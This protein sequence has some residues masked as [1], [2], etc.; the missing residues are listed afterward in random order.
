MSIK[1]HPLLNS[2]DPKTRQ[3]IMAVEDEALAAT[4][5]AAVAINTRLDDMQRTIAMLNDTITA[6]AAS[7]D[8]R[9]VAAVNARLGRTK[10]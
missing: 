3:L 6:T 9:L 10:E 2:V 4:H 5:D 1:S 7:I 8:A